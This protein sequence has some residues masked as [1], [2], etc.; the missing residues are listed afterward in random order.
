MK[1]TERIKKKPKINY[2]EI[3]RGTKPINP[4]KK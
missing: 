1:K 4:P 3:A 2:Y